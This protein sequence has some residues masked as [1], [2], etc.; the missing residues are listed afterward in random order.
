MQ[1]PQGTKMTPMLEQYVYWKEQYPDSLLFF[2]I[3]DFYEMFFEDARTASSVLDIALTSR[4]KESENAIPMAG[5]PFHSV[6]SYLAKLVAAGYRVAICEQVTVPDGKNLVQRE[7]TRLAT[8]GTWLSDG[9]D[10]DGSLAACLFE[11]KNVSIA[12]LTAATGTLKAGTFR[13][14][15]ASSILSSFR[16]AEILVKKGQ[17]DQMKAFCPECMRVSTVEREKGEFDPRSSS[18]WLCRKW[19]IAT[20]NSM[21]LEDRDPACGAA[22]AALRYLEETQFSKALHVTQVIPLLPE[23][24]MILDRSTVSNLEL[25]DPPDVSLFSV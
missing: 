1:I 21:G 11:G 19:N 14:E 12:L 15:E 7:V 9:S 23:E 20:M 8:P 18:E 16:P 13:T 24:Y 6:D 5:V 3:G 22:A 25:T 10:F 2:R 4:S 17:A